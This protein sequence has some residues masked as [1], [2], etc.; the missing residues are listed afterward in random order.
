MLAAMEPEPPTHRRERMKMRFS[1]QVY[2][3]FDDES[4][5]GLVPVPCHCIID[6]TIA[7]DCDACEGTGIIYEH[8]LSPEDD[9]AIQEN[10]RRQ[11]VPLGKI[12]TH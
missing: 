5:E 3:Q 7:T 6:G 2:D 4:R 10:L 12:G 8:T 1:K 9:A 11:G